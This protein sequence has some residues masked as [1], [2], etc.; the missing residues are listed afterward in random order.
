MVIVEEDDC[1][2]KQHSV[3]DFEISVSRDYFGYKYQF[4]HGP[5]IPLLFKCEIRLE[6]VQVLSELMATLERNIMD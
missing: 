2:P 3:E 6:S 1:G 5:E 4:Q